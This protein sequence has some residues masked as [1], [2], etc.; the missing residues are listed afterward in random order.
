LIKLDLHVHSRYSA[1]D[2]SNRLEDIVRVAKAR[3]LNGFALTDH[4]TIA[5]HGEI[6]RLS[7]EDFLIIP[8]GEVSTTK[9]HV[10]GLGV[11]E[12]IPRGLEPEEAVERIHEQGG[13]AVAAH[14]FALGRS[15]SLVYRAKF[16]AIEIL[17]A[18]AGWLSNK[19]AENFARKHSIPGVAGSDAHLLAD[20]GN[21][22]TVVNCETKIEDVM[23]RIRGGETS[24]EGRP[25]PLPL[26]LWRIL[27]RFLHKG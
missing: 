21:A 1:K 9:G 18:R 19:L 24:V 17:N 27:Q 23:K 12:E 2:C 15:P 7:N 8:G 25:L 14:P 13:V 16:D 3:G 22:Y 20:I 4:D 11:R 26:T 10:I 6:R 5:G